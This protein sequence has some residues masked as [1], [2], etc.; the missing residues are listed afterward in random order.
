MK[1]RISDMLDDIQDQTVEMENSTPL[2]SQ[3][4]KELTMSKITGKQKKG[5]RIVFRLLVAAA[6]IATLTMTAFA[7][8]DIFGAGDWFRDIVNAQL[9]A[10][11]ER[12]AEQGV[13]IRETISEGQVEVINTLGEVFQEQTQTSEGTT[14]T[15]RAAYGD[16]YMLHLYL[17]VEVPV[18]TVLPDGILYE[19]CDWNAIDFSDPEHFENLEPG[20]D[21]PYDAISRSMDIETLPDEDP[22]DH[23]KDFHVTIHGQPGTECKFNDGYSK[24]FN[25]TGIYEQ[26]LD[27][28]G[29]MDG[30]VQLAPGNFSFEVG[31]T[32]ET[33]IIDLK[34][35]E[36]F[37]YGGEKT[38][39]WTHDSE[40]QAFCEEELTGETDPETGLPIH[41][42]T[43]VYEVTV[44]SMTISPLSVDWQVK[45]SSPDANRSFGLAFRVVM[46]DGTSP[47]DEMSI[48]GMDNG[49]RMI[50]TSYFTT[51]IDL[52]EIDYIII[53]DEEVGET[54]ILYL[55]E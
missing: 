1:R 25:M 7:A 23:R 41:S 43:Y 14:V 38:R 55:P 4:I 37:T 53:G 36:G 47:M 21:A 6:T 31:L 48:G 12:A 45:Y 24:Y 39:S 9:E 34:D 54:K 16:A 11:K 18:G 8:E 26:V 35:A 50:G 44:E 49:K 51:P 3:R 27:V 22:T 40:C 52:T 30:Y 2:S 28:D 29:D 10:D 13:T 20:E 42:E 5:K 46:K 19:F 15:M 33:Q 32:G 17:S